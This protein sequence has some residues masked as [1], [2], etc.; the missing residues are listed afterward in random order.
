MTETELVRNVAELR[1]L[2]SKLGVRIP[3]GVPVGDQEAF[4]LRQAAQV[5]CIDYQRLLEDANMGRLQTFRP[6]SRRGARSWRRVTRKE[7]ERYIR[8]YCT[9]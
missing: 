3:R 5:W 9:E 1:D 7:M 6:L 2:A 4:T 8:N